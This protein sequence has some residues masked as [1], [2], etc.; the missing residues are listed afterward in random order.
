MGKSLAAL[1]RQILPSEPGRKSSLGNFCVI[2]S[3]N[4]V[5]QREN[6]KKGAGNRRQASFANVSSVGRPWPD[7]KGACGVTSFAALHG[8]LEHLR[9]RSANRAVITV[10]LDRVSSGFQDCAF[11]R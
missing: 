8:C 3:M 7:D 5:Q 4:A 6:N 10:S 2:P 9:L 1:N 11:Q